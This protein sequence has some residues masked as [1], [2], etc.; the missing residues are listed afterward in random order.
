MLLPKLRS[1]GRVSTQNGRRLSD[2]RR[3][4]GSPQRT[5]QPEPPLPPR[6]PQPRACPRHFRLA[7]ETLSNVLVLRPSRGPRSCEL[8]LERHSGPHEP[9]CPSALLLSKVI[10]FLIRYRYP[11]SAPCPREAAER[12][13]DLS[14]ACLLEIDERSTHPLNQRLKSCR[15]RLC[16]ERLKPALSLRGR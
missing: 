7:A 5:A 1:R 14:T 3:R 6:P 13:A 9:H 10:Q 15:A 2:H 12:L 16:R 8:I 4:Q 11:P